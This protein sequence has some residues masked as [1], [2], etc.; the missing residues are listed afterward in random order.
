[1]SIS[2]CKC[3]LASALFAFNC[4]FDFGNVNKIAN[5][6]QKVLARVSPLIAHYCIFDF[7]NE[8]LRIKNITKW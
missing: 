8:F 5:K 6:C 2:A 1:M 3:L 7:G 4:I